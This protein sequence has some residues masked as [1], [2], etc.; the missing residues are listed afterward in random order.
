M[1]DRERHVEM[2]RPQRI[3]SDYE[4]AKALEAL[5]SD[6][7][8]VKQDNVYKEHFILILHQESPVIR[9]TMADEGIIES[10]LDW[11]E[12]H[13]VHLSLR[14]GYPTVPPLIVNDPPYLM[15]S[16]VDRRN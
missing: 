16:S 2:E 14:Q 8:E 4:R 6:L 10:R 3:R 1:H 7:L 15:H 13:T 12:H 11:H 5:N 9:N